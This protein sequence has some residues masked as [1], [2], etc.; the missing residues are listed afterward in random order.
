MELQLEAKLYRNTA[1]FIEEKIL[2][3]L[4]VESTI[5]LENPF[6]PVI[7]DLQYFPQ[8][9]PEAVAARRGLRL[10]RTHFNEV[11]AMLYALAA[12][13]DADK[14]KKDLDVLR[15][16][17]LQVQPYVDHFSNLDLQKPKKEKSE[18]IA[19]KRRNKAKSIKK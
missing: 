6:I 11:V 2:R 12:A 14:D 9:V 10:L 5:E 18:K 13:V 4:T 3:E 19:T 15:L 16:L 1:K 17:S 7:G 8:P